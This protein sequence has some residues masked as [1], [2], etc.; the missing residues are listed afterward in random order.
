MRLLGVWLDDTKVVANDVVVADDIVAAPE[1][2]LEVVVAMARPVLEV[3]VWTIPL[4]VY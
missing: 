3:V 2:A 1:P 4:L